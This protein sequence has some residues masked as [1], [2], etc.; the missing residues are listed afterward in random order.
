M[1]DYVNLRH[2]CLKPTMNHI[3]I[4]TMGRGTI[5]RWRCDICG[6]RWQY[7]ARLNV[8]GGTWVC[9]SK[10][11]RKWRKQEAKRLEALASA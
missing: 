8:V 4:G 10:P 3:P 2:P 1:I 7:V 9:V 5:A 11:K 6:T